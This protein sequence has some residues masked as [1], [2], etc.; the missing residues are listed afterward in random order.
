MLLKVPCKFL[1]IHWLQIC[2]G[3][4]VSSI[5]I[6]RSIRSSSYA[7]ASLACTETIGVH[8]CLRAAT[9]DARRSAVPTWKIF[10][11]DGHFGTWSTRRIA[12]GKYTWNTQSLD[13]DPHLVQIEFADTCS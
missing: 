3:S 1:I 5:L 2:Q 12:R 8:L 11:V 13:V 6:G 9:P 4:G 10:R 7:T